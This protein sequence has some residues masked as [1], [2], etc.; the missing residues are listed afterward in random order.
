M[1]FE[2][3]ANKASANFVKHT[4]TFDE[5]T[6]VFFDPNAVEGVDTLHS[7]NETRLFVIGFSTRRLLFVVFVETVQD[8]L[9][10]ISARKA[11]KREREIYERRFK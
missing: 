3:D 6:E 11:N 4:V 7:D 5:A 9:R 10:L 1:R 8:A 2:W